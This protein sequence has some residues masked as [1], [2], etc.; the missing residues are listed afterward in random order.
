MTPE[1]IATTAEA[2]RNEVHGIGDIGYA[3]YKAELSEYRRILNDMLVLIREQ[4][5]NS[6]PPAPI[7]PVVTPTQ[8]KDI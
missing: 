6:L 8:M 4:A 7:P 3:N 2:L 1:C 5:K